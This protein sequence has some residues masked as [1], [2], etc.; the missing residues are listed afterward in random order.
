MST[1]STP[2]NHYLREELYALV[3]KDTGIFDFIQDGS[4]D[5]IWYW[6][7]ERPENE[8]MSPR[9]WTTL[10]YDPHEMKHLA[11]EWQ[12]LIDPDDLQ[13]AI[14][15]FQRHCEDPAHPYDQ[16][17]RYRHKEGHTVWV[18]CR[19]IAIRDAAGK[20]IRMLGAHADLT[21]SK[22]VEEELRHSE[23]RY[24]DLVDLLPEGVIEAD[25][26]ATITYANEQAF[27]MTGYESPDLKAGLNAFDIIAPQDRSRA[28]ENFARR[29]QGE[30]VGLVHYT[31]IR[32]DGS[33]F[34]ILLSI[35][36]TGTEEEREG[37]RGIVIDVTEREQIAKTLTRAVERLQLIDD[38]SVD[39]IYSYDRDGRFTHASRSLC[40]A[41]H[42]PADEIIGRTHAE[43]GFPEAQ[44]L[45]WDALHHQVYATRSLVQA[46]TSTPMPGGDV[47]RYE[48][49]LN[50][51]LDAAGEPIGIAGTTRDITDR[52]R[53]R[54]ALKRSEE[55]YRHLLESLN[56]GVVVHEADTSIR[57]ANSAAC[58][59]LGLGQD[60][61]MGRMA[62]DPE[63]RFVREDGTRMPHDEYPVNRVLSERAPLNNL[64]LG[65]QR[66][67][68]EDT[69]WVLVNGMPI[70]TESPDPD[71]VL[72]TFADITARKLAEFRMREA[73]GGIVLALSR[74]AQG[75][76]PYTSGHQQRVAELALAI[77]T[78]LD[79]PA[80]TQEAVGVASLLH[81]IGKIAIPMEILA[82]PSTPSAVEWEMI[83]AHS[84]QGASF[85]EGIE[86]PWKIQEI[87]LQHHERLDGSGYPK[88][89]RE[90]QI[91][92]E[93]RIIAVSDV[94]EAMSSHRPYRPALGSEA[95]LKVL[96]EGRGSLF[97]PDVVDACTRLF[98]EDGFTFSGAWAD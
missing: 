68:P 20:P 16:I 91:R 70:A 94:V 61:I 21:S 33:A 50:P 87:I 88:G 98:D 80:Q 17:V 15:N 75:R 11:S 65:I 19:G 22:Q 89:L 71:Q 66:S 82:K 79:L 37:F 9:F 58:R 34:P 25:A 53:I 10:G 42:R 92:L 60:D 59:M 49:Y 3:Q 30:D 45:E 85:L 90:E 48:V 23:A 1:E 41:L 57:I 73:F 86:L 24:R 38:A 31:A 64:V 56:A 93:A 81:D 5:G 51:I 14:A 40:K 12:D 35:H 44:C 55:T 52:V 84:A 54:T 83:R 8:W 62:T 26:D 32:K 39:F 97:D 28:A 6:D 96:R 74:V 72:I 2:E 69:V 95:A 18:R 76:D 4:L 77:A 63:W 7:L 27:Q 13:V 78:A 29:R 36:A 43:L 47:R 46:E 67:G